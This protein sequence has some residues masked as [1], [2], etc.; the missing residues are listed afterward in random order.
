MLKRTLK[1]D[2]HFPS[3]SIPNKSGHSSIEFYT[4][5]PVR[6]HRYIMDEPNLCASYLMCFY[7]LGN[8]AYSRKTYDK[9]FRIKKE[10]IISH[11]KICLLYWNIVMLSLISTAM[12]SGR[13]RLCQPH[14]GT[15]R[16]PYFT[17]EHRHG[18]NFNPPPMIGWEWR[19]W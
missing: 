1:T 18:W 13:P 9:S 14:T 5:W 16:N 12:T 11:Y 19:L 10:V 4:K 15:F 7:C 17:W 6:K 3:T 8:K 2:R